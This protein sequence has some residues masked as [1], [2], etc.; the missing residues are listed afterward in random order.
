LGIGLFLAHASI[1]RYGGSVTIM[2]ADNRG[3]LTSVSLPLIFE[4]ISVD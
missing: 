4:P 3:V 1:N 2:P